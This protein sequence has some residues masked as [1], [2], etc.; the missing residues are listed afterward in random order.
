MKDKHSEEFNKFKEFVRKI[1]T[2]PK[3]EIDAIKEEELREKKKKTPK[4][5]PTKPKA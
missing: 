3:S 4:K 1:V 2:V 5:Q